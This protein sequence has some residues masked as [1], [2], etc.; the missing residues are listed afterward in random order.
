VRP[1]RLFQGLPDS[2]RVGRYHSLYARREGVPAELEVTAETDDD[3]VVMAVEHRSLPVAGVQ[4]H[5]ESI[6]TLEDAIGLRL[7]G[8]VL[9]NYASHAAT[10]PEPVI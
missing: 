10:R 5:P 6:L 3:Q 8:N 7:I 9:R 4:F 1:G 2:F